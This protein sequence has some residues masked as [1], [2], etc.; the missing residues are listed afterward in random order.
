MSALLDTFAPIALDELIELASLQTRVDRKY[1][2]ARDRLDDILADL[3]PSTR[4]LEIDGRRHFGYQSVYFDTPQLDSY[5]LAAH[6]RRRRFKIRTRTYLDSGEC[7]L[8]VKT[9]GA[10]SATVKDRFEYS[11]CDH[12]SLT[13]GGRDYTLDTLADAGITGI[14][15][16]ELAPRLTTRYDRTTLFVPSSASRATID[17]N[18]A[19]IDPAGIEMHQ[20]EMAIVETKSGSRASAVDR[21]LWAHGYRPA[22]ISKYATGLAALHP[23]LGSNKWA[24]VLRR[25]FDRDSAPDSTPARSTATSSTNQN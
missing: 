22:T 19:W 25:N 13:Q 1:V 12:E 4:V 9:R 21:V 17:I 24:R 7:Y 16:D 3:D 11:A 15:V 18:L 5:W 20:P 8:E 2:V 23:D 6:A 10:R 14:D